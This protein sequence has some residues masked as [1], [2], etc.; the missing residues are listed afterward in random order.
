MVGYNSLNS[1]RT[2]RQVGLFLNPT[3]MGTIIQ[4]SK[5]DLVFLDIQMPDMSGFEVVE[6]I[7]PEN[8]PQI[9]FVT[10]YDQYALRAFEV[11]ALDYLL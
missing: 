3:G 8:F 10:A 1:P 11:H 7:G 5:P 9:V 2:R 4:E 6:R